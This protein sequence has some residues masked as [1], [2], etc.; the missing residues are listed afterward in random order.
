MVAGPSIGLC[1]GCQSPGLSPM[2]GLGMLPPPN[3]FLAAD[4][5]AQER[6]FPLQVAWCAQCAL[7]QLEEV[8]DPELLFGHYQHMSSASESN[9]AHLHG[10]AETLAQRFGGSLGAVLEV[11]CNDGTLL[12]ALAPRSGRVFG[13]DPA[14]NLQPLAAEK[15]IPTRA[16]MFDEDVAASIRTE[17]GAFDV[18]VATNVV[19]HTPNLQ[20][21]LRGIAKV[22]SP[23]GTCV[24]EVAYLASNVIQGQFDTVYHEHVCYF[25]LLSLSAA[26]ARCGLR[27]IGV[28]RIAT[29]GGSLRVFGTPQGSSL[30][31]SAEVEALL[32]EETRAGLSEAATYQAVGRKIEAFKLEFGRR[33]DDLRARHGAVIGLGAPARGVIIMNACELGPGRIDFVVDDTPLKQGRLVPGVHVPVRSWESLAA[34]REAAFVAF[35]WNYREELVRKLRRHVS[36]ACLLIPFPMMEE[37]WV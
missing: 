9:I 7:L 8:P 29:Q 17:Q 15:G 35:S 32:A 23:N 31:A 36:K 1:R 4:E 26:M 37:V 24:L 5:L 16:A 34:N 22:L 27:V 20:G 12:Q 3:I 19:A 14:K 13:V 6:T 25:S 11:G 21:V 30:Q 10:L 2:F 28:D 33:V 18:V